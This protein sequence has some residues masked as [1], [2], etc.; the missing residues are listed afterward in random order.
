MK[1]FCLFALAACLTTTLG[2]CCGAGFLPP[3][4]WFAEDGLGLI[5]ELRLMR[6]GTAFVAGGSL[7]L[8]GAILQAAL[9]NPL[10]DP[11]VLGVS[12]GSA[13]GAALA[14]TTGLHACFA[15]SVPACA[16][17]GGIA[18]LALVLLA[19]WGGGAERILLS[20][21]IV[22]TVCSGVLAFLISQARNDELA[23]I[24]WWLLGDLQ[25]SDPSMLCC[26]AVVLTCAAF[27]S[28]WRAASLNAFSFGTERAWN[29]GAN[30]RLSVPLF[31]ATASLL[32]AS[33]VSLAG[34]I[35]FCGLV[36]PHVVR[37]MVGANHRKTIFLHVVVGGMFLQVCD[38]ASRVAFPDAEL[39]IG[40]ATALIGGPAFLWILN[41][42]RARRHGF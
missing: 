15:Y 18:I 11:Y 23:G 27:A 19:A 37:R 33:S 29:L 28:Q 34:I 35:G 31:A 24:F 39:P 26:S 12:G 8:S 5:A 7:A 21:V 30:P 32:A 36:V 17:A 1:T 25:C 22:G 13:I 16:L 4:D 10:A 9:R 3:S 20:G 14:F 2:V 42:G 41:R 38:T 40:V 6:M